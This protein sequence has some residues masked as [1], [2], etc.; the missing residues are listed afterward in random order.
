MFSIQF[1][2]ELNSVIRR[3]PDIL[4]ATSRYAVLDQLGPFKSGAALC[5]IAMRINFLRWSLACWC[6]AVIFL[7]RVVSA[8]ETASDFIQ[9]QVTRAQFTRLMQALN[10]GHDQRTIVD[11]VFSNYVEALS[12]LTKQTDEA[13]IAA[14]RQKI[15][16]ALAGK[17]RLQP[18]EL[19][20]LRVAVLRVYRTAWPE[21]DAIFDDLVLGVQSMLV[22]GQSEPLQAALRELR[23]EV[24]LHPRQ[25]EAEYHGYAGEGV[26]ILLLA[27]DAMK[28]VG[29]LASASRSTIADILLEYEIQMDL[30]LGQTA[31]PLREV[32]LSRKIAEI[33][34][35]TSE[36]DR[37][38]QQSIDLWKQLFALNRSAVDRIAAHVN[39][40]NRERWLDRF[41]RASFTWLFPRDE[42]D[43][44]IDWM[45]REKI[46]PEIQ[47]EADAIYAEYVAKRRTIARQAIAIMLK[48][49]ME[50]QVALNPMDPSNIN[51]RGSDLYTD[52][53]KNSGEQSTLEG[54]TQSRLES[55]LPE[56]ERERLR[57]AMKRANVGRRR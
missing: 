27:A 25:L 57:Q 45:R 1:L 42:P 43:L 2:S 24:F 54:A 22:D 30:L 37:L 49:R 53:L 14:G 11:F 52:L 19:A 51:G 20:P 39:D 17:T 10:L 56:A 21:A 41:D 18:Q 23:R 55:L 3:P 36:I 13:A 33:N 6:V 8:Q 32:R 9:P 34:K 48:A 7:P 5:E 29:E 46:D 35:D 4:K 26:D 38:E 50:L 28:P 44:Q 16:D 47:A 40:I 12:D 15:S 31:S